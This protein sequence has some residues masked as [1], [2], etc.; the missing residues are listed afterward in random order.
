MCLFRNT[1]RNERFFIPPPKLRYD[2]AT[3]PRLSPGQATTFLLMPVNDNIGL[4][5]QTYPQLGVEVSFLF[6][7]RFLFPPTA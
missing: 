1:L 6:A 5:P 7:F 2:H 3:V 4:L